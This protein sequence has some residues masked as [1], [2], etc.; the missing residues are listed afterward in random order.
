MTLDIGGKVKLKIIIKKNV[1]SL[2]GLF[3]NI[4]NLQ[5]I[6]FTD[7]ILDLILI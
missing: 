3:S 1:F 6:D 5:S 4:T 2:S 7:L